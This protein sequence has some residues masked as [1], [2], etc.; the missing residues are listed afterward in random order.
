MRVGDALVRG[1]IDDAGTPHRSR[2][3]RRGA[4]ADRR[5]ARREGE[6]PRDRQLS[7]GGERRRHRTGR[8]RPLRS[9]S[10]LRHRPARVGLTRPRRRPARD[11]AAREV[12]PRLRRVCGVALRRLH[13]PGER[14][15]RSR[16]ER[17]RPRAV[18]A[19][20]R[21]RRPL[22]RVVRSARRL[23]IRL[24]R[25]RERKRRPHRWPTP[26]ASAAERSSGSPRAFAASTPCSSSRPHGSNGGAT[27]AERA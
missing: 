24:G 10:R 22:R 9:S 2:D 6:R 13:S 18:H 5:P 4:G 1:R 27:K 21:H 17:R 23:R 16:T 19:Q 20:P 15:R 3:R 12:D 25:L 11:R 14:G 26:S 8:V 7:A